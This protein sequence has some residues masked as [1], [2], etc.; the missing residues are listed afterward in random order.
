[1]GVSIGSDGEVEK[2]EAQNVCRFDEKSI[3]LFIE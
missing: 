3:S 1:M 2:K